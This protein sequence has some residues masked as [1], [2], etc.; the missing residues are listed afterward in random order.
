MKRFLLPMVFAV[1]FLHARSQDARIQQMVDHVNADSIWSYIETLSSMER[2][3]ITEDTAAMHYLFSYFQQLDFDTVYYHHYKD[4][5][6][7]NVVAEKT[8]LEHP[9]STFIIGGHYDVYASGAPGADDNASGTAGVMEAARALCLHDYDKSVRFICFSGEEL[10]LVGSAYYAEQAA[11]FD[12]NIL[13]MINLDMISHSAT[14]TEDPEIWYAIN[15]FSGWMADD[16]Q[17]AIELYVENTTTA[18]GSGSFFARA[19]DHASFWDRDFPAIFL[20]DCL[21]WDSPNFNNYIHTDNDVLGTSANNQELA[22]SITQSCVAMLAHYAGIS[23]FS[24]RNEDFARNPLMIYPN[25][26]NQYIIIQAGAPINQISV[27]N[28]MGKMVLDQSI[29]AEYSVKIDISGLGRGFYLLSVIS[30][31]GSNNQQKL[32][33]Y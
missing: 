29:A 30:E 11:I 25:P 17:E 8:G 22:R 13:A 9:D 14:G 33:V 31:N 2:Y 3:S 28:G 5:W 12:E 23:V 16:L 1:A 26:A 19:S 15:S 7:P 24:G 18:N 27:F 4:N 20:N 21:D 6:I 10:G 32:I